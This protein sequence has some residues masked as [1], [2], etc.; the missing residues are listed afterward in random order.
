MAKQ[1]AVAENKR[2]ALR[3]QTGGMGMKKLGCHGDVCK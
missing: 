2:I 1:L 3:L